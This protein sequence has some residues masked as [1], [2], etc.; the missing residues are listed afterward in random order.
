VDRLFGKFQ[1]LL[2]VEVVVIARGW[3]HPWY[4]EHRISYAY[5]FL[6]LAW[7][8][9]VHLPSATGFS[10]SLTSMT[11]ILSFWLRKTLQQK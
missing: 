9:V 8:W 10:P 4:E 6:Q 5:C 2:L 3:F 7:R 1:L 11:P